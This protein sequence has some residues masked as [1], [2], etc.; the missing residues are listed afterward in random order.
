M[1]KDGGQCLANSQQGTEALSVTTQEVLNATHNHVN[2]PGG[3]S[4]PS[5]VS[6]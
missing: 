2:E 4:F 6:R 3:G 1:T 5:P